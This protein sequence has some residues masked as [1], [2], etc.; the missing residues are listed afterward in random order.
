MIIHRLQRRQRKQQRC[1]SSAHT[2]YELRT[3][4]ADCVEDEPL[5]GVVVEGAEGVGDVETVVP[6]V[7]GTVE[8]G[9]GV[10]GA[11]EEVLPGV[12]DEPVS[13]WLMKREIRAN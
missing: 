4:C 6:A 12:D 9:R 2:R 3:D 13:N 5:E 7:E 8:E 10:H 1:L 11:V